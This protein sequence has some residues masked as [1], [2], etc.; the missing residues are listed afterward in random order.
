M[1]Y[2]LGLRRAEAS[3][4]KIEH[5]AA[6]AGELRVVGKGNKERVAFGCRIAATSFT[7]FDFVKEVA[8]ARG[9]RQ[10]ACKPL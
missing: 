7:V 4:A 2:G 5:C 8:V 3:D 1:L 6:D 10:S 9:S